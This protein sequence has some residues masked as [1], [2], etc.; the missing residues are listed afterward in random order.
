MAT[1]VLLNH[2]LYHFESPKELNAYLL[3]ALE[4]PQLAEEAMKCMVA[5]CESH[6]VDQQIAID[7]IKQW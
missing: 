5:I 3:T 4:N 2:I 7:L 6:S 1:F